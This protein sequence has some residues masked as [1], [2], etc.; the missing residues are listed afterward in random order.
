MRPL[1]HAVRP[2]GTQIVACARLQRLRER[3]QQRLRDCAG[4]GSGCGSRSERED[5]ACA[6]CICEI[7]GSADASVG[8]SALL[9]VMCACVLA[10]VLAHVLDWLA[11]AGQ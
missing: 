6:V 5:V 1:T 7:V 8:S 4:D 9:T 11:W 10:H 3:S 2:G